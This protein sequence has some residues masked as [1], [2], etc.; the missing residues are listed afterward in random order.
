MLVEEYTKTLKNKLKARTVVFLVKDNKVLLGYKKKGF[1]KGYYIG[2]GGKVE[3]EETIEG[4]AIREIEEEINVTIS[5]ENLQKVALLKFYFPHV[6]DESWNQ[7]VHAY[8]VN[9]WDGEPNPTEEIE[10][11]WFDKNELP[12]D[13]MWDDAQYW[14]P[15][16]LKGEKI[17]QEYLFNEDLKVVET[18][19]FK[20][21]L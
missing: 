3:D 1:G 8:L 12:L 16:I 5:V 4:A 17:Y 18:Q 9:N 10:P 7:E 13:K 21:V 11:K 6:A 2:I 19:P 14:I 15:N 20:E